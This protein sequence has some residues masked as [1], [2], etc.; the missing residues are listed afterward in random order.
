[1]ALAATGALALA[2]ALAPSTI[3]ADAADT[4]TVHA[5]LVAEHEYARTLAANA[6]A[7][8]GSLERYAEAVA[9][10]CPG[11][12]TGAP[13]G[14]ES[15]AQRPSSP[16]G[17]GRLVRETQELELIESELAVGELDAL[18][19]P[20]AASLETLI[21]SESALRWSDPRLAELAAEHVRHEQE[22]RA[23]VPA[24]DVCADMRAWRASGFR[25][26]PAATQQ[27]QEAAAAEQQTLDRAIAPLETPAERALA[28]QTLTSSEQLIEA[29]VEA[30][31]VESRLY[32]ALGLRE[33]AAEAQESEVTLAKGT[34]AS[35]DTFEV[36]TD[37]HRP[38]DGGC[39]LEAS[40]E[41][42]PPRQPGILRFVAT[43]GEEGNLCLRGRRS[44][45]AARVQCVNGVVEV[46]AAVTAGTRR[47][48][49]RLSNGAT[50]LSTPASIPAGA[51]G[52]ALVYV[53]AVRGPRPVPVS[54]AE[55]GANGRAL[56]T[57]RLAAV[58]G[59]RP[60]P[61]SK[62]PTIETL[63]RGAGPDGRPFAIQGIASSIEHEVSFDLL[64]Q[65]GPRADRGED[66]GL[67]ERP[68]PPLS[69]HVAHE[70]APDS[71]SLVYGLLA[72]PGRAVLARTA[73]GL[74][75]L[76]PVR[77]AA[78][79]HAHGTLVY[80]VFAA[81]PKQ[82]V[83]EGRR[84]HVLRSIALAHVAEE[85]TAFCAGYAEG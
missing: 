39:A 43:L 70:C 46:V 51:G 80:G 34:T 4:A 65:G 66:L 13:G 53:Q 76:R 41:L 83:V 42:R 63:V 81:L 31:K 26:L 73:S 47:V 22:Q 25:T 11:V 2:C 62:P 60:E 50:I 61:P 7:S 77:I 79:L 48:R 40:V 24:S 45:R 36:K 52:P 78:R 20:D 18:Y 3:G 8:K 35:G 67:L 32:R 64:L 10:S 44:H 55:L 30:F 49:L 23:G 16:R 15:F 6:D 21:A 1:M 17:R 59:C 29:F 56:R 9:T 54:L 37:P 38:R 28:S 57:V 72:R 75:P 85:Q 33:P 5:Y 58:V 14:P 82:L 19:G 84:G 71:Y 68:T 69:L 27:M 12:L 74:T